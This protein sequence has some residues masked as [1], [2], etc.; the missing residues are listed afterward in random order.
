MRLPTN[1]A[2]P[3]RYGL[4]VQVRDPV[5]GRPSRAGGVTANGVCGIYAF[6]WSGHVQFKAFISYSH[7][8]DGK[9]APALQLALH[10]F[11]RP[12]YKRRAIRVFRDDTNLSI[13]PG[14]WTSIERALTDA[15]YFL[16]LA[17]PQAAASKWVSKEVESWLAHRPVHT[18]LIILTD[19]DVVWDGDAMDMD[20]SRTNALPR[21][22]RKVFAEEPLYMDLR[23][24]KTSTQLSLDNA[25]FRDKV[26]DLAATLHGL[27]KDE[28]I[29]EDVRQHRKIK[30]LTWAAV[31]AL[32]LLTIGALTGAVVAVRQRNIAQDRRLVSVSQALATE[33]PKQQGP[34]K[35]D[36]RAALLARQAYLF[37]ERHH[38]RFRGQIAA[39][40]R[41]VLA[42]PF[43]SQILAGH[44]D[45]VWAVTFSPD[46]QTLAS[47]S[48]DGTVRL[49]NVSQPSTEA[50]VL[51]GHTLGITSV[52]FSL[53]G[54]LFA[55]AGEDG[56]VRVWSV[57]S[58]DKPP[59]VL[60]AGSGRLWTVA[61]SP[62]GRTL[63]AGGDDQTVRLWDLRQQGEPLMLRGHAAS[64]TSVA[65]SADGQTL[66]SGS[67]DNTSALWNL[68]T[69]TDRPTLLRGHASPVTA[70][71]F[72]TD[73]RTLATASE[74]KTVRLW[75]PTQPLSPPTVIT[76]PDVL[77]ALAFSLDG[78]RLAAAG[79]D[80]TVHLWNFARLKAAPVRLRGHD[81]RIWSIAFSRDGRLATASDDKTVRL[82]DLGPSPA[83]PQT[84]PTHEGPIRAV[85]FGP[86]GRILATGDD[87]AVRV[88]N[89]DSLGSSAAVL[90]GDQPVSS[91]AFSPD[92]LQLAAA[93]KD[94]VL[95]LWDVRHLDAPRFT[96]S[97]RQDDPGGVSV[98]YSPN[99]AVLAS[100]GNKTV[101]LRDL[102][103]LPARPKVL[104]GH[105]SWVSALA[106]SPDSHT[107]ASAGFDNT[108]RLWDLRNPRV[109]STVLSDHEDKVW[110]V[111]F[112]SNG[113]WLA[114][115]SDDRTIRI[116]N[117][118]A[119]I[120]PPITLR[121]H[122]DA[123]RSVAASPDGYTLASGSADGTIRL[124]DLRHPA[125][126]PAVLLGHRGEVTSVSF[127]PNG[128][129]LVSGG[130]DKIPRIWIAKEQL[131]AD[132]VCTRVRRN[133]TRDEWGR[134]VGEDIAYQ[135]TCPAL[136]MPPEAAPTAS[137]PHPLAAPTLLFPADRS[138]FNHYPRTV[139]LRWG[140]TPGA[141]S[142]RVEV[143]YD[144]ST[145][146]L[147]RHVPAT[148]W[149]F[150][151][152]G[153]QSGEWRVW[154]VNPQGQESPKSDWRVFRFTR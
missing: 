141:A 153:A 70:V 94:G 99:G 145:W 75:N 112:F 101:R 107:L 143:R 105:E 58:A 15:E 152:V 24:A 16:L 95:R 64:I 4:L 87:S 124:W 91:I 22:L 148:S 7:A 46:G 121:G 74:D 84:L 36:E 89:L 49:W 129:Y 115:G 83:R 136:P 113:R 69:P 31:V 9:L 59:V 90:E 118:L 40:L 151:F 110:S 3:V 19:G 13:S 30:R 127:S 137:A 135:Q 41:T 111:A 93:G 88:W 92:G 8:A 71:A 86:D 33:A 51:R 109:V 154:S 63:A 66:A 54:N 134:F 97:G 52:A 26:G 85:A 53:D 79:A 50:R 144:G 39:A 12:W 61:F 20:W 102:R 116:W 81:D 140:P 147:A 5:G 96:F 32:T 57:A 62:D 67:Y 133:L 28:L 25:A 42:A 68:T 73:G 119:P 44:S 150:E 123:V 6:T 1:H 76:H 139:T 104:N 60:S 29:G 17:S 37:N 18:L 100:A 114:S 108:V 11:A 146:V 55:A 27:P 48:I 132:M 2:V 117:L 125:E 130:T 14:L 128:H 80:G 34:L 72:S 56:T 106:F 38:G 126:D 98:A 21:S 78:A 43:F 45:R 138:V 10:R 120:D 65:F 149:S 82:Y 122:E 23:W 131:L 47:G 103:D 35:Q 77:K 142:Y